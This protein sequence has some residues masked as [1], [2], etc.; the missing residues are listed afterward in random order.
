M[1]VESEMCWGYEIV[2]R[3]PESVWAPRR[4]SGPQRA[5]VWETLGQ[6]AEE[7]LRGALNMNMEAERG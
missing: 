7:E 4:Y 5:S 6:E 3:A 2:Q 1:W